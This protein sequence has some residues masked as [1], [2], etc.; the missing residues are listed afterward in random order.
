MTRTAVSHSE[1]AMDNTARGSQSSSRPPRGQALW[2]HAQEARGEATKLR[3]EFALLLEE[4]TLL[5][6]E[7]ALALG[8]AQQRLEEDRA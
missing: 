2:V 6:E 4:A 8:E 3:E 5:L 7:A 1:N